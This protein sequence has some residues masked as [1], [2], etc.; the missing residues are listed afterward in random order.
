MFIVGIN[1]TKRNHEVT[2]IALAGQV[3]CKGFRI[4]NTCTE[5]SHMMGRHEKLTNL[6]SQFIFAMVSTAHY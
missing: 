3:V 6:K 4:S 2:V 5:Y 1:V